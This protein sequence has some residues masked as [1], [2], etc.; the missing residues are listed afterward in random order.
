[1]LK[2]FVQAVK[3]LKTPEARRLIIEHME[4]WL[5]YKGELTGRDLQGMG[6]KGK[7]IGDALNEIKLAIID[8]TVKNQEEELKF[9]RE[10]ILR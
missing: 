8:G 3:I 4:L 10:K 7:E 2:N 9:V 5:T 6:L 1:M